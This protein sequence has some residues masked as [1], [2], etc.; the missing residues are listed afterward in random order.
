MADSEKLLSVIGAGASIKGEMSFAHPVYILGTIEGNLRAEREV[1]IGA[2]ADCRA[3]LEAAV[4]VVDGEVQGN[5]TATERLQLNATARVTGDLSASTLV[6]AEGASFVGHCKV[7][8]GSRTS[9]ARAQQIEAKPR[10]TLGD[11]AGSTDLRARI[12]GLS[13]TARTA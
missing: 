7:G 1:Q 5:I 3:N 12:V 13:Q 8:A 9:G 6:I 10:V 4:V 11:G 2:D